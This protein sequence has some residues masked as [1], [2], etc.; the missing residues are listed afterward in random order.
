[1]GGAD[2]TNGLPVRLK[3][4]ESL[5]LKTDQLEGLPDLLQLLIQP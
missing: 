5:E 3:A 1:M 2:C 4:C